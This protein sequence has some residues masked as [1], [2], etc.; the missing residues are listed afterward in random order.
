M[1]GRLHAVLLLVISAACFGAASTLIRG[2]S[3]DNIAK[4]TPKNGKFTCFDGSLTIDFSQVWAVP[5]ALLFAMPRSF[6]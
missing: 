3:P 1:Y 2:A 6:S 5:Q 4:Y